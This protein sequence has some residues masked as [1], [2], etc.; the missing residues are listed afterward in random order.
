MKTFSLVVAAAGRG[1][2][3]GGGAPKQYRLLGG[4]MLW[5]WS[6]LLAQRL[7]DARLIVE[8]VF[9]VP[10]GEEALFSKRLENYAFPFSVVPGGTER[11]DSVLQGLKKAK[12]DFVLVHDAARPF[13]SQELCERI[14][15]SSLPERGVVPL[16][17]LSD[18]LKRKDFEGS[19]RPFPRE[20]LYITQTPQG[21]LREKLMDALHKWGEGA[22]D[23]GEA[24]VLSGQ[25]LGSVQ[26]ERSNMKITWPED[27]ALGEKLF[28][29]TYRT[30]I[31]YDIHPL[32]PGRRFILGGVP[33]PDFPLGFLGHSD[34]DPLVHALCDAILG[35]AGLGDIGT[36]FPAKD[37]SYRG[38]SSLILLQKSA[39]LA[40]AA[41]WSLEWAD[42]VVI[43]QAPPLAKKISSMA[44]AMEKAL[45][46]E[47]RRKVHIKAKSGEGEGAVGNCCSIICHAA[48]TMFST[49]L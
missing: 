43:A 35:G 48:A 16:T 14:I 44:E 28:Q 46:E 21:F 26:G 31:G 3:A 29:R 27:F 9:V 36:L 25:P 13:A 19:F 5:E 1:S 32:V 7:F 45:P 11:R 12:G 38:I 39:T 17:P 49:E 24:W 8:G 30:G 47:W 33:F 41:G 2:R 4:K 22:K 6:A 15:A 40:A 34:G 20:G 37:E 42:C 10:L 23:E 18:A